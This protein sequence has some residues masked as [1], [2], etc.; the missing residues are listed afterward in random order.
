MLQK[1]DE[2]ISYKFRS[3]TDWERKSIEIEK[4]MSEKDTELYQFN[5]RF[6]ELEVR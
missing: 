1:K 3:S 2:E 6:Q 4:Q 5:K